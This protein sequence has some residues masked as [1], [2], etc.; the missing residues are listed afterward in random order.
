M[1]V[2]AQSANGANY[3]Q[4]YVAQDGD[5][6]VGVLPVTLSRKSSSFMSRPGA[7]TSKKALLE[8][9]RILAQRE[10]WYELGTLTRIPPPIWNT[11]PS[12]SR[13]IGGLGAELAVISINTV[14]GL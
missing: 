8:I 10:L 11:S 13:D 14:L 5:L 3:S 7:W 2:L 9:P 6:E 4:C 12:A 1:A